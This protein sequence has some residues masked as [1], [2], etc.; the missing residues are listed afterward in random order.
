MVL[1]LVVEVVVGPGRGGREGVVTE[2][3]GGRIEKWSISC[4]ARF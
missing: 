1:G 3:G 4:L 2:G